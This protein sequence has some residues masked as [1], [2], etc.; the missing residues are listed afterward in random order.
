MTSPELAWSTSR[1]RV[2]P[3]EHDDFAG[4]SGVGYQNTLISRERAIYKHVEFPVVQASIQRRVPPEEEA[5]DRLI[6]HQG[7]GIEA[8]RDPNRQALTLVR[9]AG[10]VG[11]DGFQQ[12]AGDSYQTESAIILLHLRV[13]KAVTHTQQ[14]S[15]AA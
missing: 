15:N 6:M 3:I 4:D 12:P 9:A 5:P 8:G 10:E 7:G 14:L 2:H 13:G 1:R 11:V